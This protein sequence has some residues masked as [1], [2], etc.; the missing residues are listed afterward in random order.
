MSDVFIE[1]NRFSIVTR[2]SSPLSS[3]SLSHVQKKTKENID[4]MRYLNS[5]VFIIKKDYFNI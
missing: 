1:K 5:D 3:S 4:S 2:N